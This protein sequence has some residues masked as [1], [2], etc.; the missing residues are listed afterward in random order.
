VTFLRLRI[1]Y[2]LAFLLSCIPL[3]GVGQTTG[4]APSGPGPTTASIGASYYIQPLAPNFHLSVGEQFSYDA[5]WRLWTAGN[6]TIKLSNNG[7]EYHVSA[8]ADSVG[9]VAML[10][11]VADRFDSYFD[12]RSLCSSHITKHTE[13]GTHKRETNIRFD[14]QKRKAMLDER[15]LKDNA[16]KHQEEDI[17][18]C[19]TDVL[20][21]ILYGATLPLHDGATYNFPLNDG[22]KT[23]NVQAHVEGH[24]EVKTPAGTFQTIRVQPEA[25]S[26]VL[27]QRGKIWVWYTNDGQHIPVLMRA[28][29]FWG[30]LTIRLTRIDRQKE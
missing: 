10:Y 20:S 22:G 21:G 27:K 18:P 26:G 16:T 24:E 17:P 29:M 13:E 28:R 14:Y 30:T 15:N 5:D 23:V 7:S 6:A 11:R 4:K 9:V 19:V 8:T 12:A 25:D 3:G 1:L 2:C